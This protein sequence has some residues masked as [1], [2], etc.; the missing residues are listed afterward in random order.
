MSYS[1]SLMKATRFNFNPGKVTRRQDGDRLVASWTP[2]ALEEMANI[3]TGHKVIWTHI[4]NSSVRNGG[5]SSADIDSLRF[6]FSHHLAKLNDT[7]WLGETETKRWNTHRFTSNWHQ[8]FNQ[9]ASPNIRNAT[10]V[11]LYEPKQNLRGGNFWLKKGYPDDS[12]EF[13]KVPALR[14]QFSLI[15]NA[16]PEF[17]HYADRRAVINP[18]QPAHHYLSSTFW[19]KPIPGPNIK[20]A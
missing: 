7:P 12:G 8:D 5:L 19:A 16:E 15:G 9:K 1:T 6:E 20:G 2:A 17:S 14:N 10:R 4:P 11:F 13:F 18:N 3:F